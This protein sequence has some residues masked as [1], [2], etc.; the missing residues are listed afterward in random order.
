MNSEASF[1]R[2]VP[3]SNPVILVSIVAL[4]VLIGGLWVT[5]ALGANRIECRLQVPPDYSLP[6]AIQV[7]LKMLGG[8][9]IDSATPQGNARFTFSGLEAGKYVVSVRADGFL[10]V[11]EPVEIPSGYIHNTV[12]LIIRLTPEPA[13]EGTPA[14]EKTV[15]LQSLRVPEQ[16]Q[17][18]IEKAEKAAKGGNL[19][20]AIEHAER[21]LKHYPD[22]FKAYNNLAVYCHQ[23]DDNERAVEL[24]SKALAL[25]PDA[26]EANSNLGRILL[27]MKQPEE[28]VPYLKRASE[29]D[30]TSA[31]IQYHLARA[32]I[33]TFHFPE[34]LEPLRRALELDPPVEHARFLLAHVLYEL[35]DISGAVEELTLYILTDPKDRQELEQRRV[36]WQSELRPSRH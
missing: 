10:P 18:E 33:L 35:G 25:N 9:L 12:N 1:K 11:E 16:A 22:Y 7:D 17:K 34:S 27:Q 23:V 20:K 32:Y 8:G 3:R 19:R 26:V 13:S 6:Q 21:A 29:L 31:E 24:L 15:V 5:P 14:G 2:P 28:A 30:Q 4:G 36:A